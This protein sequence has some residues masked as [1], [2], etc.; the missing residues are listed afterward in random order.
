MAAKQ[1]TTST[2][3]KEKKKKKKKEGKETWPCWSRESVPGLNGAL[4]SSHLWFSSNM[5]E[6]LSDLATT[7]N[8][9]QNFN[10]NL[11]LQGTN[12]QTSLV[13]WVYIYI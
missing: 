7:Q 3:R 2:I 12:K 10:L 8:Q 13:F 11:L 1:S 6:A 9:Y 4:G 5:G